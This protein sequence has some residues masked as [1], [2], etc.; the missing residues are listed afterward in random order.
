MELS[1]C[2]GSIVPTSFGADGSTATAGCGTEPAGATRQTDG[3][4]NAASARG[5]TTQ[6][7]ELRLETGAAGVPSAAPASWV[8]AFSLIRLHSVQARLTGC[9]SLDLT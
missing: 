2:G 1:N 6:A 7:A 8:G 5:M 4:L 3:E 9:R